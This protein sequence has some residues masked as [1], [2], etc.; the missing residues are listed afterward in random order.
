[1][2]Q[3]DLIV[4]S[5]SARHDFS[6]V[7]GVD[8]LDGTRQ[9]AF[10]LADRR[11]Q[12]PNTPETV[13]S[14]ASGTKGFT[15]LTVMALVEAGRLTLDLAV[16]GVLGADLPEIDDRVTIEH[17]L[18]HRSGIGDYL[19][20]SELADINDYLMPI[21]VHQLSGTERYVAALQGH[22]QVSLPDRRFAYNNSGFVVLALVAERVTGTPFE[23]LVTELVCSPA[24]LTNTGFLR[25]DALP[26]GVAVGYLEPSGLRT[27]VFHLP[28]VGS[29]DGGIFSTAADMRR[30]WTAL[31]EGRVVSRERVA[32]MTSPRSEAPEQGARYGLGFWLGASGAT[33]SL[34]GYD[35]GASFRSVHD[36]V[37]GTTH[38]V[39]A[40]TS[41]GAWPLTKALDSAL[42]LAPPA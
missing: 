14:L 36:P 29:G 30:F 15:A 39:L 35:A 32:Q 41:S 17:L 4:S 31:F 33:V 34:E 38:T 24:G 28:L 25:S 6:G 18:A 11:H 3:L 21:P 20:E 10:G 1:M 16:R 9:W 27:N 19:D 42:G 40:N 2:D 7:V 26:S 12:L 8:H 23:Q 13:F 5:L 37:G 22:P